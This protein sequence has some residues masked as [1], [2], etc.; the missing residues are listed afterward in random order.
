MIRPEVVLGVLPVPVD[1]MLYRLKT[2]FRLSIITLLAISALLGISPFA[3]M[4][5][6]QGNM[7]A[8][9][10]DLAIM[11]SITGGWCTRG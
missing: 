11:L 5:F 4:R 8:G 9:V 3:V 10:V 6:A 2:D 7:L 1:I